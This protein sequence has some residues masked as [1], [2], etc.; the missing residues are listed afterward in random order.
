[1]NYSVEK[2][3]AGVTN[4]LVNCA[5]VRPKNRVL[6]VGESGKEAYFNESL[7]AS[8]AT[9]A[10]QMDIE[11]AIEIVITKPVAD[12]SQFPIH[13]SD[14]M[15]HAD[16]TIFFSRLGDQMRFIESPGKGK[17]VM[18]YT[19]TEEYFCSPFAQ[20]DHRSMTAMHNRLVEH[21]GSSIHYQIT[22]P[23]G[24]SLQGKTG[25]QNSSG[26]SAFTDFSVDMFPVMIFPPVNVY[27]LEGELTLCKFLTS[28]STRSY[29]NSVLYI[30]TPVTAIID[31]S[32]MEDFRGNAKQINKIKY[33][34]EK[35]AQLTGGD[36]YKIN[37]WHTG[38]NPFTFFNENP[39]K[40]I[41]RWGT[42]AFGSP[43]Y[44]HF[45]ASGHNPG[46]VAIQLFDA[47]IQFDY[48]YYWDSGHF[49]F[50][51]REETLNLY[52]KEIHQQLLHTDLKSIGL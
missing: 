24:T 23:C 37:S 48:E 10:K 32:R 16:I 20:V 34:L 26:T 39:H 30:D 41:E 15:Q 50:L 43:R 36:P 31:N 40:N 8:V 28:S 6:L 7:C 35:A 51:H 17:K 21:I 38:I 4:L 22:A 52:P 25:K 47:S 44:T 27:D 14:R 42:A 18:T 49:N 33:Q 2:L 19:L 1:M 29:E 3:R 12:A 11:L 9:V 13:V 46:D 5:G 45:H